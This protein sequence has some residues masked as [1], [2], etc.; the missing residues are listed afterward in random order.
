MLRR[1]EPATRWQAGND[2]AGS[3]DRNIQRLRRFDVSSVVNGCVTDRRDAFCRNQSTVNSAEI[4]M[5]VVKA[6]E[7][8]YK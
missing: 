6:D 3:I 1:R 7:G 5:R 2:W 4:V 8:D